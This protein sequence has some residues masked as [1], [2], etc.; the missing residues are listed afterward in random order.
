MRRIY[1]GVVTGLLCAAMTM[2]L[3]PS[4]ASAANVNINRATA[5]QLEEEPGIGPAK[6]K[7]IIEYRTVTPFASTDELQNVQGI[8]A[9]LYD[10]IKDH[11]NVGSASGR[12]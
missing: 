7:A 1:N 6:A 12:N 3:L 10:R 11:V 8:G 9:K 5:A 4:V 2:P